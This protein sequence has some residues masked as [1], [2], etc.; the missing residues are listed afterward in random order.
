MRQDNLPHTELFGEIGSEFAKE[1]VY[2]VFTVSKGRHRDLDRIQPV[3]QVLSEFP[4]PDGVPEIDI[5][6]GYH[7]DVSLLDF[8]R[9]N[10][11]KFTALKHSEQFGLGG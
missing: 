7:P 11:D 10:F 4:L 9:T 3:V 1:Q 5:R 8:R 2:V 6:G